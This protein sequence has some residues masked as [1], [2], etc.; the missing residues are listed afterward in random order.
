MLAATTSGAWPAGVPLVIVGDGLQRPLV[1]EAAATNPLIRY[2]GR[3]PYREVAGLVAGASASLICK[4]GESATTG[5]LPLK[6]FESLAAGAPIVVTDFPGLR[7]AATESQAGLVIPPRHPEAL[8]R[9]AAHWIERQ[10][11]AD[12]RRRA[13]QYA[14]GHTW[15]ARAEQTSEALLRV[16]TASVELAQRA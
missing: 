5:V 13:R 12:V 2:V 1:E 10:D 3:L 14:S 16:A 15:D 8:A 4:E 9:A 6:L 11:L 7:D